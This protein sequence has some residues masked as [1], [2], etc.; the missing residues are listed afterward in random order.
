[1]ANKYRDRLWW[2][3]LHGAEFTFGLD[4]L[5]S[6]NRW[7]IEYFAHTDTASGDRWDARMLGWFDTPELAVDAAMGV[8]LDESDPHDAGRDLEIS[9]LLL[10]LVQEIHAI[11]PGV[12]FSDINLNLILPERSE[13]DE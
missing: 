9:K 10:R 6:T 8:E 12:D 5:S 7:S 11:N 1:M 4:P 2:V 13:P 3:A